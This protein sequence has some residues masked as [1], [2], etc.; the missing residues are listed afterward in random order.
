VEQS[1]R[2]GGCCSTFEKQ[3]Y[4][5]DWAPS[6]IEFPQV[7]DW[8]F[9]RM[10]TSFAK[11]VDLVAVDPVFSAILHDGTRVSYPISLEGT[12]KEIGRIAPGT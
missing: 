10:G 5:I 4:K 11:E 2:V 3:G 7:I 1:E 8:C 6:I 9:Q 12:A